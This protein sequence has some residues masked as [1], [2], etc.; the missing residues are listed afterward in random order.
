M[1]RGIQGYPEPGSP[2]PIASHREGIAAISDPTRI[3]IVEDDPATR[4]GLE[5]ILE[6]DRAIVRGVSSL[7]EGRRA[8]E[9]F[10]PDI[11]VT[12]L[13]LPDG[14]GIDFIRNARSEKA[15]RDVIVLTGNASLDTA[16]E[17]M[18]AGAFDYL[19]KPLQARQIKIVLRRLAEK[20]DVRRQ[21]EERE[22]RFQALI[23]RSSDAIALLDREGRVQYASRSTERV[24][25]Y[26]AEGFVGR[27]WFDLLHPDDVSAARN[28][29]TSVLSRPGAI[30]TGEH[31][32]LHSGSSWR[33][34][35]VVFSNLLE[36]PSVRAVVLNYR[37][38][39]D[40]KR[41]V[42][43]LEYRAFHDAL[44]GLPNRALF[45]DRLGQ[46]VSRARRED[47]RV[48]VMFIDL[49]NLKAIND[50]MGHAA[51]DELIRRTADRIR[52][53]LR[54]ADT[55]ARVGGDEFTLLLPDVSVPDDAKTVASKALAS[56]AESFLIGGRKVSITTSIGIAFYPKD[57]TEPEELVR[58]ADKALYH[59]KE[60]GKNRY[61]FASALT[62]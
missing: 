36:D 38:I 56:V 18:K 34:T 20:R 6:D 14:N 58:C 32:M 62:R 41:T 5:R 1:D 19:V 49:D 7:T 48:A 29:L 25:G 12:D 50:T 53:C 27:H 37:D 47:G 28:L 22:R 8:L 23:E 13:R 21:L 46:A 35:E 52:R 39:T 10:N 60:T 3:L 24:L 44:T 30:A 17:A 55:L 2:L 61:F 11:C 31:R 45:L 33:W 9:S 4:E 26:D 43:D 57:S 42:D 15:K 16:I 54:E 59:A 51:G 40:R